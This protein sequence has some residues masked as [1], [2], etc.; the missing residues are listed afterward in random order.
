MIDNVSYDYSFLIAASAVTTFITLP[1][2]QTVVEGGDVTFY[3]NATVNGLQR[4]LRYRISNGADTLIRVVGGNI[5]DLSGVDGVV[6]ACVL[7]ELNSQLILKGMTREANGYN[8]RCIVLDV[9]NVTF[10][11]LEQTQPPATI[12]V[13]SMSCQ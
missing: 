10:T 12:S 9:N 11:D 1:V 2:D 3:C 7:G 13:Q 8:V 4:L 6:G 5:T